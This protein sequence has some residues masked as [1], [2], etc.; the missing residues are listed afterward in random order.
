MEQL[1]DCGCCVSSPLPSAVENRPGLER[2]RYRI[3]THSEFLSGALAAL[4][5]ESFAVLRRL[6][7]REP[8][9]FT[10]AL[11]DGWAAVADVLTF[12]QE[13]LA[14][15][16]WL[17]TAGERDSVIRLAGLVGYRPKPGVA[18]Q[19]LLSFLLDEASGAPTGVTVVTGTKVQ[20]V[21]GDGQKP[22]TFETIEPLEAR[23]EWNSLRPAVTAPA[24][25]A[26]GVTRLFIRG[27][28]SQL[29]PGDGILIVGD[30]RDHGGPAG[31][32]RWDFR[33]LIGA[34]PDDQANRTCLLWE[35]GLGEDGVPPPNENVR[36]LALR[37][38]A[39]LFGHNAP[40]PRMMGFTA[41]QK[42][43]L[44]D[45]DEWR[46]FAPDG[47]LIEL[48][49]SYPKVIAPG[50]LVLASSAGRVEAYKA[51]SVTHP[52]R[53]A[54]G[55]SGKVT[56][57]VPDT[58]RN[59]HLFPRRETI[60]FAQSEQLEIAAGPLVEPA[61][62]SIAAR[63]ARDPALLAPVEG[64][65]ID[66][67]RLVAP[68]AAGR[69]VV[70]SGKRLRVRVAAAPLALNSPRGERSLARGDSLIVLGR[71][72][73]RERLVRWRL[74]T[75]DGIE[76]EVT[77]ASSGLILTASADGDPVIS[78]AGVVAEC[79]GNPS[80]LV[81]ASPPLANLLDRPTV[82]ISANVAAATHGET[83][84]DILGSGD[85][86]QSGQAFALRQ[87][88]LTCVPSRAGTGAA[89]TLEVRVNDLLW[90]EVSS[91]FGRAPDERVYSMKTADD[92]TVTVQFGDGVRGARLP[93][94]IQNVR[95][96]YRRGTGLDGLV[97]AGQLTT[98]L[99]RPPGLKS[100]VNPF[101]AAGAEDP[102]QIDGARQNAPLAML[103]L[104]R[105]VSLEDYENFTRAFAGIDKALATWTWDG[106]A[107]GVFLTVA[108]PR[109]AEVP[110][111]VAEALIAAIHGA[112]DPFV[113]IRV[114][115]CEIVRFR[116]AGRLT[117]QP[118]YEPALVLD[119]A[120][121]ALREA[122][123]F[124][125]R[126]FGQP[127]MLSEVIAVI[128]SVPGIVAVNLAAFHRAD[129]SPEL[130]RRIAPRLPSGSD[131]A[132]LSAAQLLLLDPETLDWEVMR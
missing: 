81:L 127:V 4:S 49:N 109:G 52:S 117:V 82:T 42:E 91:L 25:I 29:Q 86:A 90:Q 46:G 63:V 10:L 94:G 8:G 103:T 124:A 83:V 21:P 1:N 118:D 17:R 72:S 47:K 101:A 119:A 78:E 51:Q 58:A 41:E 84:V 120:S 9:D 60:V 123:S 35:R 45:G 111:T 32:D 115:S 105:V 121:T 113:A 95:A 23:A 122:F 56:R 129:S 85:A 20:S 30:E 28:S 71:P 74:R 93:S 59:L 16:A 98:L 79:S 132:S 88:P 104:D 92:G 53:A 54:F 5:D 13:C 66:I 67:G 44:M 125:H 14:N 131:P 50:W 128:Q 39:G 36:V 130:V 65:I 80:T 22:Q 116:L 99:T 24:R 102:E 77:A 76:G 37:L 100:V 15:E 55:I 3:G 48:D 11:L 69:K 112:G 107:Q 70:V 108:G 87:A 57:I 73:A 110:R 43:K 68:L 96:R 33:T 6:T 62:D 34:I 27:T 89:S 7:T 18:A 38:R 12:Y 61:Q 114:E 106:R 31:E 64:A 40:D 2:V 26:T 126:A 97:A 75:D 19:T